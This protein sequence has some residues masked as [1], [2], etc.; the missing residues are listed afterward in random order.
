M[1]G[2]VDNIVDAEDARYRDLCDPLAM[3]RDR[4]YIPQGTVYLDGNSLGLLSVTAE[5]SILRVIREWRTMGVGGWRDA[6]PPW[7]TLAESLAVQTAALVGAQPGSIAIANS[8]TVNLHQ[9]LCTLYSPDGRQNVILADALNF[10]SDIYAIKSHLRMRG[11][12]PET[13]LRYVPNRDGLTL[14]ENDIID[15]MSADVGLIVLPTVL[16]ASGQLLDVRQ[17]ALEA[18]KRHILIGFDCSH[19]IGVI[20]H[21]LD[22]WDV[23]FAFWCSYKY[24]NAGPGAIGGLYLNGRHADRFPGMAGW[25]GNR[26]E[27]Q[28]DMAGE[29]EPALDAGRLQIG[30]PNVLSLAALE[31]SLRT[32]L[33]A[34]LDRIRRKSLDLTGCLMAYADARLTPLGVT[35][36]NPRQENRRG[37]HVALVHKEAI[38]IC[39]ALKAAHI[40]PDF[41]PPNVIRLAPTA[42]YNSFTDCHRAVA[43]L[44]RILKTGDHMR[45]SA[46]PGLV[47]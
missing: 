37:G 45:Y 24:L 39:R 47:S 20:P 43:E 19:S 36:V 1:S 26:K 41:R 4:F 31:G 5:E 6:D 2:N 30:T 32:V 29:F 22:Q 17:I 44:E 11:V 18:R 35:V 8:T 40:V 46:E 38:R 23:D 42:L 12:A 25:F 21:E 9:L 13:N 7:F 14:L 27:T 15:A 34:G 28:F 16:Y 10:P 3:F 33:D